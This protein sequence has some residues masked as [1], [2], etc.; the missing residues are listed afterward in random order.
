MGKVACPTLFLAGEKDP[1]VFAWHTE[2]LYKKA[3]C[4][5][6]YELFKDGYHAEDL[7]I[8]DKEKF[9]NICTDWL[10]LNN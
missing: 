7:F 3:I 1:T 9:I 8:Q 4:P 10:F 6:K 5:K 2:E